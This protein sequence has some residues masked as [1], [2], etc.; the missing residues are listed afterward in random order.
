[1][2]ATISTKRERV[3]V[4]PVATTENDAVSKAAMAVFLLDLRCGTIR[5]SKKVPSTAVEVVRHLPHDPET[6]PK[7]LN[8]SKKLLDC[9]EL[10]A[11][12]RLYHRLRD[13]VERYELPTKDQFRG[14][15]YMIE[16]D[17]F[18]RVEAELEDAIRTLAGYVDALAA[19][20]EL[21]VEQSRAR[22]GTLFNEHD[23]PSIET[24]RNRLVIRYQYQTLSTPEGLKKYSRDIFERERKK[25]Q[26]KMEDAIEDCRQ[27][28][29]G[30]TKEL[31]TEIVERVKPTEGKP[32]VFRPD[33]IKSWTDALEL[34]GDK[35]VTNDEELKAVIETAKK[36]ISGRDVA[37]FKSDSAVKA[38]IEE[39]FGSLIERLDDSVIDK[40]LRRV[41]WEEEG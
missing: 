22:L 14:G 15:L 16:L 6:D 2:T 13:A 37:T 36:A 35:N 11:I 4:D 20:Y 7:S 3:V 1:M 31:L 30:K 18:E 41:H 8:V 17:K 25:L 12:K 39:A 38:E 5:D 21:R 28:V 27:I 34:L 9:E 19:N 32:K 24:L 40:P 26:A 10:E 23:Y 33:I 29:A